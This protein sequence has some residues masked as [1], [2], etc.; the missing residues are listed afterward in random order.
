LE[1]AE[2]LARRLWV[3]GMQVDVAEKKPA[4]VG[5]I[6]GAAQIGLVSAVE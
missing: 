2:I 3:H 4:A 5:K 1:G 6:H